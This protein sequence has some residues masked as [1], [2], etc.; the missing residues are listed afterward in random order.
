MSTQHGLACFPT[1]AGWFSPPTLT[2][3]QPLAAVVPIPLLPTTKVNGGIETPLGPVPARR[4]TRAPGRQNETQKEAKKLDT[5]MS[6]SRG[7]CTWDAIVAE[8][9]RRWQAPKAQ[10]LVLELATLLARR[11]L[12]IRHAAR[13]PSAGRR[14]RRRGARR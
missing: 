7:D 1:V 14:R 5:T 3:T 4:F 12:A 11:E 6:T 13:R 9:Q 10:R 8:R 2:T